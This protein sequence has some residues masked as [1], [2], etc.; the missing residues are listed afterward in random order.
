MKSK[1]AAEAQG[2]FD[3]TQD[4]YPSIAK[5]LHEIQRQEAFPEGPVDRI[6]ICS[7][8]SGEATWR[9]WSAREQEPVGGVLSNVE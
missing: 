7:L 2:N 6:E 8:P 9:V 4:R 1:D 3:P 5:V